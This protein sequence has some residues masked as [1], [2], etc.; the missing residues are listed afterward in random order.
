MERA[1]AAIA[2]AGALTVQALAACLGVSAAC[3]SNTLGAIEHRVL[4]QHAKV[5]DFHALTLEGRRAAGLPAGGHVVNVHPRYIRHFRAFSELLAAWVPRYGNNVMGEYGLRAEE[6]KLGKRIGRALMG[7]EHARGLAMRSP[8]F[9][10]RTPDG[11]LII[12]EIETSR[13]WEERF[14]D[15]TVAWKGFLKEFEDAAIVLYMVPRERSDIQSAARRAIK[16]A[17]VSDGIIVVVIEDLIEG[18]PVPELDRLFGLGVE[19]TAPRR[20]RQLGSGRSSARRPGATPAD[21]TTGR[22][23]RQVVTKSKASA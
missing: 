17:E 19:H 6:R 13:K 9:I 10:A 21:S 3:A 1:I 18:K 22:P 7:G 15:V 20:V 11:K 8:D 16:N 12:G 23:R 14:R 5:E 2:D 4:T